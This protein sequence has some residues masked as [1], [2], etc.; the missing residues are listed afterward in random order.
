M[1]WKRATAGQMEKL[2][3]NRRDD[4][5]RRYREAVKGSPSKTHFDEQYQ[6]YDSALVSLR[7]IIAILA[8]ST[9]PA[10]VE[11]VHRESCP[12]CGKPV[13]VAETAAWVCPTRMG[14]NA[15]GWLPAPPGLKEAMKRKAGMTSNCGHDYGIRCYEKVPMHSA[16][17]VG[18]F[19]KEV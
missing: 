2:L 16:C 7:R 13:R 9:P 12:R 11:P 14:R 19:A 6:R 1:D 15:P 18:E 4:C 5:L 17:Y 8:E 3:I 10:T